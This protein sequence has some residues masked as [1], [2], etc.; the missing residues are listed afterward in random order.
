MQG[1][2]LLFMRESHAHDEIVQAAA[3]FEPHIVVLSTASI[4]SLPAA[5]ELAAIIR[6]T[7]PQTRIAFEGRAALLARERLG[8]H[9]DAVVS[10]FEKGH[11]SLMRL[12]TGC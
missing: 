2:S 11:Q 1:W 10:G 4:Q 3:S 5:V 8:P 7:Y 6:Q 9:A 12:L